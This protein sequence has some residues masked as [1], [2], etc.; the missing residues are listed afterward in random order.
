M[1]ISSATVP[2]KDTKTMREK[3]YKARRLCRIELKNSFFAYWPAVC[4]LAKSSNPIPRAVGISLIKNPN[5]ENIGG[6]WFSH[7]CPR[8]G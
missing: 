2:R 1:S 8:P 5:A 7:G 4:R 6:L 3:Y